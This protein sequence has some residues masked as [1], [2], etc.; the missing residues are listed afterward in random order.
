MKNVVGVTKEVLIRSLDDATN[1]TFICSV[2]FHEETRKNPD[3]LSYQD[4]LINFIFILL[5][6]SFI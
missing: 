2:H 3:Y 1:D 5:F 6:I 4:I